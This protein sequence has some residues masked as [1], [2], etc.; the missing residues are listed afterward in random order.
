MGLVDQLPAD[1]KIAHDNFEKIIMIINEARSVKG[2]LGLKDTT[3]TI[4]IL[5]IID[6]DKELALFIL[7]HIPCIEH[8]AKCKIIIKGMYVDGDELVMGEDVY[9]KWE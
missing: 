4:P 1:F 3:M 9:G 5:D 6:S 2:F 8:L 7:Q